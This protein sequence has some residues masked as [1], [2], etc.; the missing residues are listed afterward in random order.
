M[1]VFVG[2][3]KCPVTVECGLWTRGERRESVMRANIT[4]TA[5]VDVL[6]TRR[7]RRRRRRAIDLR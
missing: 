2:G 7:R 4:T 3:G 6:R 5:S 1:V